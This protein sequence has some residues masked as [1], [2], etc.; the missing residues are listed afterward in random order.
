MPLELGDLVDLRMLPQFIV[1]SSGSSIGDLRNLS[2][3]QESLWISR[4]EN[5]T[6]SWDARRANLQEKKGLNQLVFE[7]STISEEF[8]EEKVATK[9]FEMLQPNLKL[10][11]VKIKNYHDKMFPSWVGDPTFSKLI[12]LTLSDCKR[13][14]FLPPAGQLPSLKELHIKGVLGIKSI[15]A[16]FYGLERLKM[17]LND[18]KELQQLPQHVEYVE[19]DC[20]QSLER[21][22]LD[23]RKLGSLG[24][25]VITDCPK[26]E[27]I[28]VTIFPSNLK[29]LILRGCGLESLPEDMINNISS[30][31]FLY[32]S[33]YLVLTSFPRNNQAL[34]PTTFK[35]LTVDHC[36]NIEFLPEG[37][38]QCSNIFLELLEIFYCASIPSFPGGHPKTLKTLTIWNCS[39]LESLADVIK[40]TM[41]LKSLRIGN[42]T[43]LK[44]LPS[45]LHTLI[46]L[47]YLEL[48][49][50]PSVESFPKK[51]LPSTSL[52]KMHIFN[53]E[54]LKFL[55]KR[56]QN[57]TSLNELRLSNC[58]TIASFP[59]D[60]IPINL[61]SLHIKD[62]EN[63]KPC[64]EWGLHR[65]TLLKMLSFHGCC[66]N[67][68]TFPE[69]LLPSTLE[70]LHIAKQTCEN[71][72]SSID[73]IPCIVM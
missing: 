70:T 36:P 22:P 31:E 42:C 27:S 2:H 15:G 62:C 55:A 29:G 50:C 58:P 46:Y 56:M 5:V 25:L 71:D 10:K 59:E 23:F 9:V 3:L 47:D 67:T 30:L 20:F 14:V 40:E 26:L 52:K 63:I 43:K 19:L 53:C 28:S 45:G 7:W 60:G 73:H 33:G 24:E 57:L 54:N 38:M 39:N 34:I 64:S 48:D 1:G 51:G 6:S 49:G 12:S 17:F 41:S 13:C 21:L 35:Q 61:V 4:L 16:E 66:L 68:D 11:T 32:I 44:Y 65:L 69:W 8:L 72:W 18:C 37:M